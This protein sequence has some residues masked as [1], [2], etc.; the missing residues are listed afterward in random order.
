MRYANGNLTYAVE[1]INNSSSSSNFTAAFAF[2]V[3]NF[4][5]SV[6]LFCMVITQIQNTSSNCPAMNCGLTIVWEAIYNLLS[7][8]IYTLNYFLK[9]YGSIPSNILSIITNYINQL[10]V[11]MCTLTN[12]ILNNNCTFNSPSNITGLLLGLISNLKS[13]DNTSLSSTW[14]NLTICIDKFYGTCPC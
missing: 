1:L 8:I 11:Q 5:N 3:T 4:T 14:S 13:L 6:N 12:C 10:V 9:K 7:A 2:G